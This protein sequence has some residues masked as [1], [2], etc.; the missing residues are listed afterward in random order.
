MKNFSLDGVTLRS[1]LAALAA[2]VVRSPALADPVEAE[3]ALLAAAAVEVVVESDAGAAVGAV[4][5]D[6]RRC[7]I[8]IRGAVDDGADRRRVARLAD[9]MV[10]CERDKVEEPGRRMSCLMSDGERIERVLGQDDLM[11]WAGRW[12]FVG[13]GTRLLSRG[14]AREAAS[15]LGI[16]S[17]SGDAETAI[18]RAAREPRPSS[19]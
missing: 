6:W 9:I 3:V 10:W 13:G 12:R 14:Q 18:D 11:M 4:L 16:N 8:S 2:L 1:A 19:G 17:E 5:D 15:S 7:C